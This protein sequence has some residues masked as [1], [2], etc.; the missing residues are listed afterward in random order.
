[1]LTAYPSLTQTC[2]SL[3][4]TH[5][6]WINLAQETLGL[7]RIR[8]SRILSL[9]IPSFSLLPRP[10]NLT[11]DLHPTAE[12]SSTSTLDRDDRMRTT[13]SVVCLAPII[14]GAESLDR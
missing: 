1:M 7:R 11:I 10:A 2:L 8:F 3:G 4:P 6:G 9:L 13:A 5:P 12:R 14:I